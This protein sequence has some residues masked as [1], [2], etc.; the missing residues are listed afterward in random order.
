MGSSRRSYSREFKFEAV[1]MVLESGL[2]VSQVAR[3]LG[4]PES[5]LWRWKQQYEDDP[6]QAFPGKGRLKPA[7]EE[8]Y[9]LRREL[10]R[11]RE[12]RDILKKAVGI[13]SRMPK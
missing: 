1:R 10:E 8:L 5:A 11:V 9:R 3:D 2:S 4:V 12:E 13:F 7:D 6:A